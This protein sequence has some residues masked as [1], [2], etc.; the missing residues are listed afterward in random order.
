MTFRLR[1]Q[2][3][4]SQ[5]E[6]KVEVINVNTNVVT[7]LNA[8]AITG[9]EDTSTGTT[10]NGYK[11]FTY[12]MTQFMGQTVRVRFRSLNYSGNPMEFYV[13][14]TGLTYKVF[15]LAP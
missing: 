6:L 5:Q 1:I 11:K 15:G 8:D 7:Q 2:D 12:S 10:H 13:D 9:N 3:G 14:N 4:N